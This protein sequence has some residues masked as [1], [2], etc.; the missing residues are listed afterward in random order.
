MLVSAFTSVKFLP[1]RIVTPVSCPLCA[2]RRMIKLSNS[3]SPPKLSRIEP[4]IPPRQLL[5]DVGVVMF[6]LLTVS[7]SLVA[8]NL[9]E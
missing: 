2:Y 3:Y 4:L 1:Y 5:A 9:W 7:L 8:V 6:K